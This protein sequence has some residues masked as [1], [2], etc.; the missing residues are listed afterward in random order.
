MCFKY[1]SLFIYF[2][3]VFFL[4]KEALYKKRLK[5]D[6]AQVKKKKIRFFFTIYLYPGHI[7]EL[8]RVLPLNNSHIVATSTTVYCIYHLKSRVL[9][10]IVL[11]WV[12]R[13]NP[14][15]IENTDQDHM[16]CLD[17]AAVGLLLCS[18]N[19]KRVRSYPG[20]L[21]SQE[22]T[23]R[24]GTPFRLA[25][26]RLIFPYS[27]TEWGGRAARVTSLYSTAAV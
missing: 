2:P 25:R 6:S 3:P 1:T 11:Y 27:S 23:E 7:E 16:F 5:Q 21:G 9:L 24:A 12:R 19:R 4:K 10:Q 22:T 8:K 26:N 18:H 15:D 13:G 14:S 20:G 17:P